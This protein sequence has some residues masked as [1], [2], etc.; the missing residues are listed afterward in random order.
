[1][2][3]YTLGPS[4][5]GKLESIKRGD[6]TF[7]FYFGVLYRI[8]KNKIKKNSFYDQGRPTFFEI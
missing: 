3:Y 5:N 2:R 1:M 7:L 4:K 8:K 6:R